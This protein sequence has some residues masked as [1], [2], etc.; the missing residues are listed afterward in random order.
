MVSLHKMIAKRR[1]EPGDA[2]LGLGPRDTEEGSKF[3]VDSAVLLDRDALLP[4]F[5]PLHWNGNFP[6]NAHISREL[7]IK[8]TMKHLIYFFLERLAAACAILPSL[9]RPFNISALRRYLNMLYRTEFPEAETVSAGHKAAMLPSPVAG[10]GCDA[11]QLPYQYSRIAARE[12]I[13]C[14]SLEPAEDADQPIVC[15][16][17]T[18]QL[19]SLPKFE[20]ISYAWGT[21]G[22]MSDPITCDNK[23]MLVTPNLAAA[24]RQCRLPDRERRLWADSICIDRK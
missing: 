5:Y 19:D 17:K 12:Q 7:D 9:R 10:V 11:I 23:T 22:T 15:T 24:L 2:G 16:L 18:Y 21:S 8:A 20:A 4:K 6:L 14:L 1:L 3:V 13:R